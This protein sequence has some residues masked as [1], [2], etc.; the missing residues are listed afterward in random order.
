MVA[1]ISGA[2]PGSVGADGAEEP[3]NI[4]VVSQPAS[5]TASVETTARLATGRA[6]PDLI[7]GLPQTDS[8]AA[9]SY[10]Q[11]QNINRGN[12]LWQIYAEVPQLVSEPPSYNGLTKALTTL[13]DT[14][15][16]T[17]YPR[18]H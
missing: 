18:P 1:G 6:L 17:P 5:K 11:A 2:T 15:F 3:P 4:P 13:L 12:D 16:T 8:T 10:S 9:P 7:M 14:A